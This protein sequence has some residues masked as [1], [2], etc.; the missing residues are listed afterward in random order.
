MLLAPYLGCS[1]PTTRRLQLGRE[2]AKA[3]VPR[4]IAL[5]AGEDDELM[6]T[7]KYS[8]ELKSFAGVEVQ[9]LAGI[10]HM[11]IIYEA[12]AL[13]SAVAAVKR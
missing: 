9:T 5:M 6:D 1:A 10:D 7:R 2:W 11:G 8:V 3:N 4:I 13:E 12:A